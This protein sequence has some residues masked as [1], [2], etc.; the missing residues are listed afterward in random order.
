MTDDQFT[1]LFKHIE[2]MRA[3]MNARFDAVDTRFDRLETAVDAYAKQ[4]EKYMQE[5]LAL[6]TKV[7]RLEQWILKVAEATGVK[8][9]A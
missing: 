7:D 4:S 3:E 2:K 1:K 8:L 6:G 5:M 9:V